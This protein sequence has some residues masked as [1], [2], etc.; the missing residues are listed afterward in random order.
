MSSAGPSE[1]VSGEVPESLVSAVSCLLINDTDSP[2]L[3]LEE[4]DA[5]CAIALLAVE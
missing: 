1:G 5:S 4:E 3:L 2:W